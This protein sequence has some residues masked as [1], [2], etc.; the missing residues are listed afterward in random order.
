MSRRDDDGGEAAIPDEESSVE[1]EF[2]DWADSAAPADVV[3]EVGAD[4]VGAGDDE[5]AVAKSGWM[6]RVFGRK[7][8]DETVEPEPAAEPPESERPSPADLENP[9]PDQLGVFQ[10]IKPEEGPPPELFAAPDDPDDEATD[11]PDSFDEEGEDASESPVDGVAE[12]EP[13]AE[14]EDGEYPDAGAEPSDAED[15]TAPEPESPRAE[16]PLGAAGT[17]SFAELWGDSEDEDEA[18]EDVV[19]YA[20][21]TSEDY[22][23]ATTREYAGLAEAVARAEEEGT[24]QIAVSAEIPGLESGLVGLEDVV[25]AETGDSATD[26]I[27]PPAGSDLAMRVLTAIGLLLLFGASLLSPYG[28]GAL[29]FVVLFIAAGELFA[30][31]LRSGYRPLSLFGF[32]GIAGAFGGTWAAGLIAIPIS[33]LLTAIAVLLFYATVPGRR[34]ALENASLTI[35]VT[36]WIGGLGAFAFELLKSDDYVWLVLA[37]VVTVAAMDVGQYFIGRRLGRRA[38]APVVSPKKTVEGYVAGIIVAI[39]VGAGF[40]WAEPFEMTDGLLI[41]AVV[42]IVSP[43]GDLAVSVVKRA[44]GVKDMGYIL[45]G[46]GGVLDRVDAMIVTIP[47]LWI[48]YSWMGLI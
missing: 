30:A 16:A 45:P 32:L 42:A 14:S 29:I 18:E 41:G 8:D 12:E 3:D 5:P 11:E 9:E 46:H 1:D 20:E 26:I 28:I 19:S 13:E 10:A 24:P 6:G 7:Q 22:L 38:L 48:A 36:A 4:E 17:P 21:F 37:V 43:L 23:A 15:D 39:A 31:F 44:L 40:A 35:L 25:G 34:S 2:R 47:A 33:L 27:E